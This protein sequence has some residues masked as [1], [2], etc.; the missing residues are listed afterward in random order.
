M[1]AKYQNKYPHIADC[2]QK[3]AEV[4]K[5]LRE[6]PNCELEARFGVIGEKF[7]PGV[8]RTVMDELIEI[9]QYS[10]Y[11]VGDDEWKEEKD[12]YFESNGK[13]LRTR[14]RYDSSSMIVMTE[15]TEKK[16]M[17]R[18]VDFKHVSNQMP[19]ISEQSIRI[20]LKTENEVS[21]PPNSVNPYL[22]RIKQTR[23]F[24]TE[25]KCWAF[26]FSMVWSGKN[27]SEAEYSQMTD[28]ALLEIECELIN[29][30]KM[31]NEKNDTYIAT[32]LLL[33][34]YDLLPLNS[35]SKFLCL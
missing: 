13:N 8:D 10:S 17:C 5:I 9:L 6:N 2:I 21:N 28:D 29:P 14:V 11:I 1:A 18:P 32:S 12:V 30:Q 3:T 23:R 24:V 25:N 33:K 20:S 19:N 26:D 16:M 34:M 27:K 22:V 7:K 4:V 15:T 31:L 35:T